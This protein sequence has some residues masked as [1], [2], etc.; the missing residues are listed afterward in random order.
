M[1]R[2]YD[3]EREY[4]GAHPRGNLSIPDYKVARAEERRQEIEKRI[5]TMINYVRQ[6]LDS[7]IE[8][9]DES[10]DKVWENAGDMEMVIRYLNTCP[11]AERNQLLEYVQKRLDNLPQQER[12]RAKL[13][14]ESII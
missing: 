2:R 6:H 5:N 14:L 3:W 8:R 11:T 10:V 4:K 7:Q 9:L 1:A 12:N 13:A